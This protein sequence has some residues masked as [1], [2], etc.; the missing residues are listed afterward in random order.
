MD[1]RF[2]LRGGMRNL[3]AMSC[4][5]PPD[6]RQQNVTTSRPARLREFEGIRIISHTRKQPIQ[7]RRTNAVAPLVTRISHLEMQSKR[8]CGEKR[9]KRIGPKGSHRFRSDGVVLG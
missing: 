5:Q 9:G 8:F 4:E 6:M 3:S 1:S 7:A 2:S